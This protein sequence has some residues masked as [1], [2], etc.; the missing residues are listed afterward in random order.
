MSFESL[1]LNISEFGFEFG[2]RWF[3]A[4]IVDFGGVDGLPSPGF[5]LPSFGVLGFLAEDLRFQRE[6]RDAHLGVSENGG[7]VKGSFKGLL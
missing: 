7:Y 4:L 2:L 3:T 5:D 1:R 6:L